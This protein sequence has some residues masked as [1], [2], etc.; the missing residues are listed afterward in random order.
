V[1]AVIDSVFAHLAEYFITARP[2]RGT[3]PRFSYPGF[4]T[5]TKKRRGARRGRN[6]QTGAPLTIPARSTILFAVGQ[7]LR[8]QLN[9]DGHRTKRG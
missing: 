5:F 8:A 2:N 6:P 1:A 9:R 7:E 4:G 3:S